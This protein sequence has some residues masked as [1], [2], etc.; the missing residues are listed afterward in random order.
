VGV[1]DN[2]VCFLVCVSD[3]VEF[4]DAIGCTSDIILIEML[5]DEC[6]VG[7]SPW[8]F[9]CKASIIGAIP[10]MAED[11]SSISFFAILLVFASAQSSLEGIAAIISASHTSFK[12]FKIFVW[13]SILPPFSFNIP[14]NTSLYTRIRNHV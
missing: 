13:K 11:R 6:G 2:S 7:S 3:S 10:W 5:P 14:I 1:G 4:A 8:L 12:G 9:S